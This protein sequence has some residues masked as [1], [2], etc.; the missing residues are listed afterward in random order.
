MP[1]EQREPAEQRDRRRQDPPVGPA[2]DHVPL[3]TQLSRP[4][5]L[6][7]LCQSDHWPRHCSSRSLS[8]NSNV[9]SSDPKR[10]APGAAAIKKAVKKNEKGSGHAPSLPTRRPTRRVLNATRRILHTTRRPARYSTFCFFSVCTRRVTRRPLLD[11]SYST[12][13][14]ATRRYSTSLLDVLFSFWTWAKGP[15]RRLTRRPTRRFLTRRPTRRYSTSYSTV[16]LSEKKCFMIPAS[17]TPTGRF[18]EVRGYCT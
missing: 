13:L 14:D 17:S 9:A 12:L 4:T 18:M 7:A 1:A 3:Q 15:T 8:L 10:A 6:A 11:A 16:F 2:R 5:P